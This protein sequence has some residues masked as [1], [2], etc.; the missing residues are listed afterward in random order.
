WSIGAGAGSLAIMLGTLT[1]IHWRMR[2]PRWGVLRHALSAW[3]VA[4]ILRDG[5]KDLE[6]GRA[7]RWGGRAYVL[8]SKEARKARVSASDPEGAASH[9]SV[10]DPEV[11]ATRERVARYRESGIGGFPR[12]G[13]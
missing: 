10:N 12:Q 9:E 7:V 3:K 4:M 1:W 6:S 8:E 2:A 5:A 13:R 11:A